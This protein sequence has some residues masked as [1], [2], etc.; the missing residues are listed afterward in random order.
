M[1]TLYI[2]D[3]SSFVYRSFFALPNLSTSKGFPTNAIYGFLRMIFALIKKEKPKYLVVVFD[4]PAKTKRQVLYTQYKK[5]RPKTPDPLKIQIPVLKETLRL[6]GIPI[7]EVPGYE[8]D[9]IIAFL[10]KKFSNESFRVKIYSPDKDLLQ[11]VSDKVIVVN[12]M[13][14]E[15]FNEKKVVEKFGVKPQNIPDY[16]ALVGDKVDNIP[17]IKGVGPKTAINILKKFRNVENILENWEAFRKHYP[18][19]DKKEL[20]LSYKLVKLYTD[21]DLDVS[22]EDLKLN[23]PDFV[24]L[25]QKLQEL[26]MKS[27]LKEVDRVFKT[28]TQATLF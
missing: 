6:A 26:E 12:P 9:D 8:A 10:A 22:E 20:E 13:N 3:G 2:L 11:L 27:L 14:E 17:G 7:F 19:A 5:Q 25:K 24:K 15:V 16:L 18:E 1:K 28:T 4:A 23:K 21:I